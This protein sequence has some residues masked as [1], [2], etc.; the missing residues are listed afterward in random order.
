MK[1]MA[2]KL[3][4]A[5]VRHAYIYFNNTA[6]GSAIHNALQ[7]KQLLEGSAGETLTPAGT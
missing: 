7:L 6:N 3:R 2:E 5:T 1:T 4:A